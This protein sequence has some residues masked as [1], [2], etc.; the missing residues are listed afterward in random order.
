MTMYLSPLVDVN[1]IDLSTTIP[2]VATS[3]G[4][5]ILRD[6]WKGPE[7]KV[8][9]VNSIDELIDIF[10]RPEGASDIDPKHGQSYEDLL[11]AAGF[12][13]FGE[14]LYCTRVLAPSATFAGVYGTVEELGG[15]S[16]SSSSTS[17]SSSSSCPFGSPTWETRF[18][19]TY[20]EADEGGTG[21]WDSELGRWDS[22]SFANF[23]VVQLVPL[24]TWND[25]Y[26][27]TKMRI[28]WTPDIP[29]SM[30]LYYGIFPD[31]DILT[32]NISGSYYGDVS[33]SGQGIF[34]IPEWFEPDDMETLSLSNNKSTPFSLT[35]VEFYN[36]SEPCTPQWHE[37]AIAQFGGEFPDDILFDNQVDGTWNDTDQRVESEN[38]FGSIQAIQLQ[39]YTGSCGFPT[40]IKIVYGL[41][42]NPDG[43][44]ITQIVLY[45]ALE[46]GSWE[47]TN[48]VVSGGVEVDQTA[49]FNL[50]YQDH[51]E[52]GLQPFDQVRLLDSGNNQMYLKSLEVWD[53]CN[54]CPEGGEG[55]EGPPPS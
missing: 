5:I 19:N 27:P 25:G 45:D 32:T 40:K 39:N 46:V 41:V 16:N 18:N 22:A 26:R 7:L 54:P 52:F 3:I 21:T 15:V 35:N 53:D 6:T 38:P 28:E 24:G 8:Q 42:T 2:A 33:P 23:E 17:N 51:H 48:V 31:N 43:N 10:G 44:K 1:E 13:Q 50:T 12:L 30:F 29:I 36:C 37:E 9:L 14:N 47:L 55:G 4:V 49:V 34:N 11:A 20:W